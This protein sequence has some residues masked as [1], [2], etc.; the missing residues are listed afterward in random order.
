MG[1]E[2]GTGWTIDGDNISINIEPVLWQYL[3]AY[4]G[5]VEKVWGVRVGGDNGIRFKGT[6]STWDTRVK[7]TPSLSTNDPTIY[8]LYYTEDIPVPYDITFTNPTNLDETADFYTWDFTYTGPYGPLLYYGIDVYYST[9]TGVSSSVYDYH[10]SGGNLT[11][12]DDKPANI[13]KRHLLHIG[14]WYARAYLTNLDSEEVVSSTS[15]I[16]FTINSGLPTSGGEDYELPPEVECGST[17]FVCKIGNW[18]SN[19]VSDIAKYLFYPSAEV[20]N[21]YQ[22]IWPT[23]SGKVPLGYYELIK[24]Q[25]TGITEGEE[26]YSLPE[27]GIFETIRDIIGWVIWPLFA[28]YA[29]KRIS[30][31]KI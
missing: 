14:D 26:A 1:N 21:K 9:E 10:D 8:S 15:E 3:K 11:G 23:I 13:M 28:F 17:D 6:T 20:L 29:I 12:G 30:T 16:H 18:F 7:W 31:M 2:G 19:N 5:G 4:G 22:T 25:I 24:D 27:M